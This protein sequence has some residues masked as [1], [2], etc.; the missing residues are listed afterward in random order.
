QQE[1]LKTQPPIKVHN[2]NILTNKE[3]PKILTYCNIQ[4]AAYLDETLNDP[5]YYNDPTYGNGYNGFW[6]LKDPPQGLKCCYIKPRT[7]PFKENCYGPHYQHTLDD[8]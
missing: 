7:S 6:R 1:W 4:N 8:L 5:I 3:A 2:F